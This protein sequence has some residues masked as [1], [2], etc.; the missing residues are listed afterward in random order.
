MARKKKNEAT[1]VASSRSRL[2]QAEENR[3]K[4]ILEGDTGKIKIQTDKDANVFSDFAKYLEQEIRK[5]LE[6]EIQKLRELQ[7]SL[8]KKKIN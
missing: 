4:K 3:I 8:T 2:G 7:F 5:E 6:P 1:K